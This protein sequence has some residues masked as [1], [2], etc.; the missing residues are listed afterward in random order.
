MEGHA[1]I[2]FADT[3]KEAGQVG[4]DE[5]MCDADRE[6]GRPLLEGLRRP[7]A[8]C[9]EVAGGTKETFAGGR[10]AHLARRPVQQTLA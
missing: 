3:P 7:S 6:P 5:V 9:N 1:D 4:T 2:P 10:E 8:C